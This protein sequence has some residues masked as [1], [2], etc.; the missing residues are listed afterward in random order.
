MLLTSL[1]DVKHNAD[2]SLLLTSLLDVKQ[3]DHAS[4]LLLDVNHDAMPSSDLVV[5][6]K[7]R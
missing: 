1:L 4:D 5:R 3:D 6:R 7:A 2:D